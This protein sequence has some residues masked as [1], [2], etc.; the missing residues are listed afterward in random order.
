MIDPSYVGFSLILGFLRCLGACALERLIHER[1]RNTTTK[2]RLFCFCFV[3][4]VVLVVLG[5]G[6]VPR[7]MPVP[8][9]KSSQRHLDQSPARQKTDT[10]K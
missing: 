8:V 10:Q 6:F 4:L 3:S 2:T 1:R 7:A 5:F 9:S